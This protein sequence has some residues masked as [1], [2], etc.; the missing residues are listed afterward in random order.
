MIRFNKYNHPN[1]SNFLPTK[2]VVD[3]KTYLDVEA[4]FQAG[5]L[6]DGVEDERFYT[7]T[8]GAAKKLGRQ[9]DLRPDWE[10]I[11]YEHMKKCVYAKFSQYPELAEE[12]LATGNDWIVEDTTAW[13]DN[14]WGAC[15]CA[16]C[17]GKQ[18]KNLMGRALMEVRAKLRGDEGCP[19]ELRYP[20]RD[21][22]CDFDL[23]G[24]EVD[25]MIKDGTWDYTVN[26]ISRIEE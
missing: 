8:K 1:F 19:I 26:V 5:K 24:P 6:K 11:K 3:G 18:S 12:L 15:R 20:N 23:V 21:L 7:A 17:V 25:E 10:Q 16:K 9:V 4:A 22:E 14:I 13:H 2:I